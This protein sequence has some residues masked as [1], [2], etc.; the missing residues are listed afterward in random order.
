MYKNKIADIIKH[1]VCFSVLYKQRSLS[2]EPTVFLD[3]NTLSTDGTIALKENVFSDDGSLLAYSFS[4]SGVDWKKI[5]IRNIETGE[6]Y[7][8]LL[9]G[10]KFTT[11]SWTNDNK[12][13]F[14]CVS[15]NQFIAIKDFIKF[16]FKIHS[17]FLI[18]KMHLIQA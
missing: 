15:F 5:K 18:M 11:M 4:D 6:D 14:Y 12:G 1:L 13:F 16:N 9:R 3:P 17:V 7:P 8:D 10:I 2:D